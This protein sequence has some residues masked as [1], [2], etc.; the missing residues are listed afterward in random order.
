MTK[1]EQKITTTLRVPKSLYDKVVKE[2]E[3]QDRS[4]NYVI[5]EALI[6]LFKTK[7]KEEND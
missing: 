2:A 3:K 5:N 4:I 1:K 6:N 7:N